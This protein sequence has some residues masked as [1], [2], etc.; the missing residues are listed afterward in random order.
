MIEIFLIIKIMRIR[1][2]SKPL[3]VF[4]LGRIYLGKERRY[5]NN[6]IILFIKGV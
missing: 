2:I 5:R 3:L 1:T 6:E 4:L